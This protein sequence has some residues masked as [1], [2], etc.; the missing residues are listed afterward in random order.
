[1]PLFIELMEL[2]V[3][4]YRIEKMKERGNVIDWLVT[5]VAVM[6]LWLISCLLICPPL[7]CF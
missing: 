6:D 3:L 4:P 7:H 5:V 1:V 2:L